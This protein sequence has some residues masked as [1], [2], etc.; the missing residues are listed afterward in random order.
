MT[1]PTDIEYLDYGWP[2]GSIQRGKHRQVIQGVGATRTLLAKESGAL[3]LFDSLTGNI[4]TLPAP[5]EG[6]NFHFISILANT[7][8]AQKVITSAATI[9]IGGAVF[10]GELAASM[11]IFQ[12]DIAATVTISSNGSTTGGL[13]G[14]QYTLTALSSTTWGIKGVI[15]GS[16]T[17]ATPFA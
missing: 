4:Y 1:T 13:I 5:V 9:F 10:S 11:D 7:S 6:M 16:G 8:L 17:L 14:S 2:G 3:C 12:A 15:I